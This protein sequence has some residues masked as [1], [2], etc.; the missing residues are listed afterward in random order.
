MDY[1]TLSKHQLIQ[2]LQQRDR[3][4]SVENEAIESLNLL[5][6]LHYA[7]NDYITVESDDNIFNKILNSLL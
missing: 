1:Q 3:T 2:L 5:E 4:S 6:I 7:Q